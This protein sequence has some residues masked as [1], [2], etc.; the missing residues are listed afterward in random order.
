MGR[1]RLLLLELIDVEPNDWWLNEVK[2]M[3]AGNDGVFFDLFKAELE[4]YDQALEV[5]DNDSW[6]EVRQKAAKYIKQDSQR[7]GKQAFLNILN[8]TLAYKYLVDCGFH[9]VRVTTDCGLKGHKN[10]PKTP[11]IHFQ[12]GDEMS[13]CEVKTIGKS[14][15]ELDRARADE[16]FSGAVYSTLSDGFL[17]KLSSDIS[18]A[19]EQIPTKSMNNLVYVIVDFDDFMGLHYEKYEKQIRNHLREKHGYVQVYL[20]IGVHG[21]YY[22]HHKPTDV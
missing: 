17:R 3:L 9:S 6:Q 10:K 1:L 22:I 8:E 16:I 5:V 11:D 7:R 19:I 14:E 12:V 15:V 18:D 4:I 2:S 21:R 20:R 13:Y